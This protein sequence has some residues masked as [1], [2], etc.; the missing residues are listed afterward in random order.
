M[1]ILVLG[2]GGREHA[3]CWKIAQSPLVSEVLCAP[4]NCGTEEV[5]RNVELDITDKGAVVSLA[6]REDIALVVIGPE[7]VLVAGVADALREA[8]VPAFGPGQEG[9]KLEGSKVYSK[10][11]LERHRIP[12]GKARNF[13][14]SGQAKGYLEGVE[15]WPLVI[16]ADGLAAGKGVYVVKNLEEGRA[17]VD[18]IMEERRHG[19]SGEHILIEEFLAGE[20]ASVF[21]ITDGSTIAILEV[22]QDHK[23]VGEGD[24]GPNTGGMGVYSPVPSL[25]SRMYKQIEQRILVPTVHALRQEGIAYQG[26]LFVGLMLTDSGPQVIEYNVRFGDPECQALMR[27]MKSDVVPILLAAATSDMESLEAPEWDPRSVVGVV[28]AAAGYPG[29]PQKGDLIEGLE[30]A[31]RVEDVVVFHAG[32]KPKAQGVVTNGGRVLCVTALADD[33]EAA[34]GKAYEAYDR[35][36]WDGKFCRRDIGTRNQ[37]PATTADAR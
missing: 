7:D 24:T 18:A 35:I 30:A 22:V 19:K 34:R 8:G 2:S 36:R 23:Q 13:D 32:T 11:F 29:T 33:M 14:R 3:L 31:N 5:A 15:E 6:R 16:K 25:N 4:G 27:R 17:A 20:E 1:K 10:D 9:A 28:A 37:P 12:T 21:A 26:V